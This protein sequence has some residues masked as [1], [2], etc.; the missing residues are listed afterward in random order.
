M[1]MQAVHVGCCWNHNSLLNVAIFV[2]VV[3]VVVVVV[4]QLLLVFRRYP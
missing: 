2:A 1:V 4:W 3:V